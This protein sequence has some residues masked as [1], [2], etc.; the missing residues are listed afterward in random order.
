MGC[1]SS[2]HA[3][4]PS[5]PAHAAQQGIRA[6][7]M[8]LEAGTVGSQGGGAAATKPQPVTPDSRVLRGQ[9][10][11]SAGKVAEA[12]K[13]FNATI[14]AWP[15]YAR[16]YL[17]RGNVRLDQ[18]DYS[19]AIGD[20]TMALQLQ[21]NLL[22]PGAENAQ[23]K[24]LKAQVRKAQAA[25]AGGGGGVVVPPVAIAGG[26]GGSGSECRLRPCMH[27]A[28][29]VACAE[30]LMARGYGC[31]ICSSKIEQV[32]RG[33][34][35]RTFTVE[36]AQGVVAS[37]RVVATMVSPGK[38]PLGRRFPPGPTAGAPVLDNI[39]EG[40]EEGHTAVENAGA[41]LAAA[42]AAAAA[43]SDAGAVAAVAAAQRRN[44]NG[45]V[46][47][48]AAAEE[49]AAGP[50][51]PLPGEVQDAAAD[52]RQEGSGA[53]GRSQQRRR[54]S[55][56]GG[57]G[58]GDP[59][60]RIRGGGGDGEG[61][62]VDDSAAADGFDD[63]DVTSPAALGPVASTYLANSLADWI[64]EHGGGGGGGG[65]SPA[66]SAAAA[67]AAVVRNQL[68][69]VEE[70]TDSAT[71][72]AAANDVAAAGEGRRSFSGFASAT[73]AAAAAGI[74]AATPEAAAVAATAAPATEIEA[75]AGAN[76]D[77][78]DDLRRE[79]AAAEEPVEVAA[80][81]AAGPV[82]EGCAATGDRTQVPP[83]A[84]VV[85]A[86]AVAVVA[87]AVAAVGELEVIF[88]SGTSIMAAAAPP[89]TLPSPP[90]PTRFYCLGQFQRNKAG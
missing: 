25:V 42:A 69:P 52:V 86:A 46:V 10:Y 26:G 60:E 90:P 28:L 56:G 64:D 82:A 67:A 35:M 16:A 51:P 18:K 37:A 45:A 34:F 81:A 84:A 4:P 13:E 71:G 5:V 23:V 3:A 65:D 44:S 72:A 8:V 38:S 27:A 24:V 75:D 87:V 40:D 63:A 89:V 50:R 15:T 6:A 31:P 78:L 58:G 47:A 11:Y 79:A 70:G 88:E 48:A 66:R 41:V 29:C 14:A 74:A 77:G 12:L 62:V 36:E 76:P 53:D 9:A 83:A 61:G 55:R 57:S 19:L 20:Y 80:T 21:G 85:A 1:S 54:C 73:A 22:Q 68:P 7:H 30:G 39:V 32:E 43:A 59:G 33:S 2:I 49:E 17:E